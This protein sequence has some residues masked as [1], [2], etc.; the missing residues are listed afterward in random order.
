MKQLL[1]VAPLLAVALIALPTCRSDERI[2]NAILKSLDY[3]NYASQCQKLIIK[4]VEKSKV[5]SCLTIITDGFHEEIWGTPFFKKQ[6]HLVSHFIIRIHDS[7]DMLNPDYKTVRVLKEVRRKN[8]ELIFIFIL[9]GIQAKRFLIFMDEHRVLNTRSKFILLYDHRIFTKDVNYI[10]RRIL[11][12][13]FVRTIDSQN[14]LKEQNMIGFEL[15]T[16]PFP[17]IFKGTFVGKSL[18]IWFN[19]RLVKKDKLFFDKTSNLQGHELKVVAFEHIPMVLKKT[20]AFNEY[21]GVEVEIVKAISQVMNFTALYYQSHDTT[22]EKW[23]RKLLNGSYTG[24]LGE[25]VRRQADIAVADLHLN[26]YHLDL[27]DLSIPHSS[28][29][30]TFLTPESTTDNSWKTFILPLSVNMWTGV[31]VSLFFAGAVFYAI[32]CIHRSIIYGKPIMNPLAVFRIGRKFHCENTERPSERNVEQQRHNYRSDIFDT[33]SNCLLLTYSM[34]L[35]V[36]LPRMPHDWPLRLVTGWY[37]TYCIQV[38]VIYR[39][40]LTAILANPSPRITIDTLDELADSS[41]IIGAWGAQNKDFFN[42]AFD[43]TAQKIADKLEQIDDPDKSVQRIANGKYAYYDNE[44]F[45]RN[46]R[47][48]RTLEIKKDDGE[49]LHIMKECVLNVPVSIGLEKNSPLKPNID[50]Y[51]RRLIEAGLTDKWLKDSTKHLLAEEQ[52][53]AEA[54][55][56]L[57]KFWSSLVVLLFGYLMAL[58]V[59]IGECLHFKLIVKTHPMYDR[60]NPRAYYQFMEHRH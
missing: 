55:M 14:D 18:G 22:D 24:L 11:S 8:C 36:A 5:Q 40:S 33:F 43:E 44:Y 37:W 34:Q 51:L 59:L 39:A 20:S 19:G 1:K 48:E 52:P 16:V 45:L 10:W 32:S 49:V 7:E 41:L 15:I 57:K 56:D 6:P 58:I 2:G 21:A 38:V 35:Q 12:V 9:N 60:Y 46:L 30:L 27:M 4:L 13:I 31:L 25:M 28:E 3:S 26:Q 50:K 23:G 54:L 53:P 47:L 17:N 29:C 42:A